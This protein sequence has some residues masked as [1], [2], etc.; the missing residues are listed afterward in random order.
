MIY[1]S[2]YSN[3]RNFKGFLR[4]GISRTIPSGGAD[5]SLQA[6]SP[7]S[8]TLW[9]YKKGLIDDEEYTRQFLRKLDGLYNS[10]RLE[11]IV[12]KLEAQERD[13]VLLCYERPGAFCHRRIVAE[14]LY[15]KFGIVI[16]EL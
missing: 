6:F 15:E 7:D 11:K 10:G 13:I 16:N 5:A 2:Y 9:D 8:S 12:K 1:T 4:I 3:F 14:Y